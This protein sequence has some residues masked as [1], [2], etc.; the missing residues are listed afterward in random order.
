MTTATAYQNFRVQHAIRFTS[1]MDEAAAKPILEP[2]TLDFSRAT[3]AFASAMLPVCIK[4]MAL[5]EK[6]LEVRIIEPLD[7]NLRKLFNNTGW[8]HIIEP[9]R[10]ERVA[11]GPKLRQFPATNYRTHEEQ[12]QLLNKIME[13]ILSVTPDLDRRAFSS[14]EWALNEIT[15]NVL[16]HSGSEVG[17]LLQLSVFN[18]ATRRVEFTVADAG[19]SIPITLGTTLPNPC[20]DREILLASVEEGVTRNAVDFQGNGLFGALEICRASRGIFAINSGAAYLNAV[21]GAKP[22]AEN[23]GIR[24]GITSIDATIDFS[25]PNLLETAL[26]FRGKKHT[27][28]D[29]IELTYETHD[30]TDLVVP[31]QEHGISIRSRQAGLLFRIKLQNLFSQ[32]QSSAIILDFG[33]TPVISSSFADEVLGKLFE[34]MGPVNFSKRIQIRNAN[35]TVQAIIDR[36]ILQRMQRALS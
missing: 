36:S 17:G 6:G 1:L 18:S 24:S 9:D 25:N 12:N 16:N 11:I 10:F 31:I 33:G 13:L 19:R 34:A 35:Q 23:T 5:R 29:Y 7:A 30:S 4:A 26:V 20:S 32:Y 21:R 3:G 8:N 14:V 27:P 28:V 22:I 2:F 15:D